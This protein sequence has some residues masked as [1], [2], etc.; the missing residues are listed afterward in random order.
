MRIYALVVARL[1]TSSPARESDRPLAASERLVLGVQPESPLQWLRPMFAPGFEPG[2]PST[3]GVA[4]SSALN[5]VAQLHRRPP[6]TDSSASLRLR[7]PLSSCAV[8]GTVVGTFATI[9]YASHLLRLARSAVDH[10]GFPCVVLQAVDPGFPWQ[11]SLPVALSE[12]LSVVVRAMPDPDAPERYRPHAEFCDESSGKA[13]KYGWRRTHLFKMLLWRTVIERGF[14]LFSMDC[15]YFFR[16]EPRYNPLPWLYSARSA[17]NMSGTG[18]ESAITAASDGDPSQPAEFVALHHD[19]MNRRQLNIGATF[20]R[21]TPNV[22]AFLLTVEKRT[23]GAQDQAV[24]NE[25]LNWGTSPLWCCVTHIA[26]QARGKNHACDLYSYL[27]R[28]RAAQF[29]LMEKKNGDASSRSSSN[30]TSSSSSSSLLSGGN[31]Q[32]QPP[33]P[34]QPQ[35]QCL[36]PGEPGPATTANRN[37]PQKWRGRSSVGSRSPWN[38]SHNGWDSFGYNER[39]F[40]TKTGRCTGSICTGCAG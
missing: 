27:P 35:R 38:V 25:E 39:F 9:S 5:D 16:E 17:V 10:I 37:S 31:R 3:S 2:M 19:G 18:R 11:S 24:V 12:E 7:D 40:S 15:D 22:L 14:N 4:T 36:R 28:D 8:N 13:I 21:S 1:P 32:Q 30:L 23:F 6:P 33:P 20:L 29:K 26:F 34:P